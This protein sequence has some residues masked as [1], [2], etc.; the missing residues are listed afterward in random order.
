MHFGRNTPRELASRTPEKINNQSETRS[1]RKCYRY[2]GICRCYT[3]LLLLLHKAAA[4]PAQSRGPLG[5]FTYLRR[6]RVSG[7]ALDLEHYNLNCKTSCT[8]A[9]HLRRQ[10]CVGS[11]RWCRSLRDSTKCRKASR[12]KDMGISSPVQQQ[13]PIKDVS[14][15][16][17]RRVVRAAVV[18]ANV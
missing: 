15:P 8:S 18:A 2:L 3:S 11:V 14:R 6:L 17:Q 5:R 16:K 1:I 10:L 12:Y 7:A 9:E 13:P 4:D